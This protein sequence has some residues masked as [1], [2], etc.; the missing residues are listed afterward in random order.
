[1]RLYRY[2]QPLIPNKD[3]INIITKSIDEIEYVIVEENIN[4]LPKYAIVEYIN[5]LIS[6]R[7]GMEIRRLIPLDYN[8]FILESIRR[9]S[10]GLLE[11]FIGI[12][13]SPN[14]EAI[15]KVL[16]ESKN[17]E[18]AK[19]LI[20]KMLV[21]I[22]TLFIEMCGSGFYSLTKDMLQKG[23]I[24]I[25]SDTALKGLRNACANGNINA[26]NLIVNHPDFDGT[27]IKEKLQMTKFS[28]RV[29][30]FLHRRFG[31]RNLR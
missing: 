29:W 21:S 23:L 25:N 26:I 31:A 22:D 30:A 6:R 20:D 19:M 11:Y 24:D 4:E 14:I 3:R 1:M 28:R 16:I 9:S 2:L 7:H 12:E 18:I 10:Y 8:Q 17:Y 5:T 15:T 13:P 27:N